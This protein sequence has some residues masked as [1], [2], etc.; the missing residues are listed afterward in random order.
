MRFP[1]INVIDRSVL[2]VKKLKDLDDRDDVAYWR[3]LPPLERMKGLEVLR[4][5]MYNYDP[6]T[7]RL[8]RVFE[9]V[10][11]VQR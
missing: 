8:S 1:D 7:A 2:D 6:D 3:S 9:V 4:Q 10:R 11:P 5:S